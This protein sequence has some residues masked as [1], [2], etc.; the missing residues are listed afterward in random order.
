MTTYMQW[1]HTAIVSVKTEMKL[2]RFY[3]QLALQRN[4]LYLN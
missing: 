3:M 1:L 4:S 2:L